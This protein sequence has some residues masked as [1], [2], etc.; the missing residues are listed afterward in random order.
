MFLNWHY[1]GIPLELS[2]FRPV[3]LLCDNAKT[4]CEVAKVRCENAILI[5][6]FRIAL[7]RPRIVFSLSR[8]VVSRSRIVLSLSRIVFSRFRV[9][10]QEVDR[11]KQRWPQRNTVHYIFVL[12]WITAIE[13][14]N[15]GIST[16]AQWN[17]NIC[18]VRRNLKLKFPFHVGRHYLSRPV[19]INSTLNYAEMQK[20]ICLLWLQ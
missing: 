15:S 3:D 17:L 19:F 1:Y 9:L 7:S 13:K 8:I 2:L 6:R 16:Y 11:A 12:I 10:T 5:S 14:W 18:R 20:V 4:R